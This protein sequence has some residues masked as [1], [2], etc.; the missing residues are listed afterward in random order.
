MNGPLTDRRTQQSQLLP[1]RM[2]SR[3]EEERAGH[4]DKD[5]ESH[6]TLQSQDPLYFDRGKSLHIRIAQANPTAGNSCL[7]STGTMIPARLLPVA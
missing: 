3:E 7:S 6:W 5:N 2:H 1:G 4:D